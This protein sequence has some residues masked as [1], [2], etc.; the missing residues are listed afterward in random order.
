MMGAIGF[1]KCVT[2]LWAAGALCVVALSAGGCQSSLADENKKLWQENRELHARL[3]ERDSMK[4][5]DAP[6]TPPPPATPKA[7]E[8]KV[9]TVTPPRPETPALPA[10]TDPGDL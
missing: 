1:R 9:A 5:Q 8:P 2:G 6:L 3:A 7:P 4:A 10:P